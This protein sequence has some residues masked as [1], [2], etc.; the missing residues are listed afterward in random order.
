MTHLAVLMDAHAIRFLWANAAAMNLNDDVVLSSNS[1][2]R[3]LLSLQP[4]KKSL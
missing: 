3:T 1:R 2:A 4:F